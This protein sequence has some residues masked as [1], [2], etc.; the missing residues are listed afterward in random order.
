MIEAPQSFVVREQCRKAAADNGYRKSLGEHDGWAG[1]GSTTARGNIYLAASG[2]NGPWFFA[3]EHSGVISELE[4]A[5]TDIP[6]PG[7]ARYLFY[8]QAEL[9]AVLR[10]VY[11]L[12][13][14]LPDL[15]LQKFEKEIEGLPRETEA[16]RLV[17]Q[18]KGQGIF[19]ESL[20]EYWQGEC[21][22]TGITDQQLLRAS[23]I[24]PWADCQTDAERLDVH[25]GLLLSALW[26]AAFDQGLVTFDEAGLPVFSA[27][28]SD[29]AKRELGE[30]KRLALTSKHQAFLTWHRQKVFKEHDADN[31]GGTR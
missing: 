19:R 16:E 9:Y 24:K 12:S 13:V 18:R 2:Q 27:A 10:R 1:Y 26:D 7:A 3:I 14:S 6:G 21:P 20:I 23:H 15:P 8:R 22:L 31:G 25:N 30:G 29:A 5:A 17:V 11:G 4:L 28:L